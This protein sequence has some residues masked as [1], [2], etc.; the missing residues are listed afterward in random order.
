MAGPLLWNAVL[1][2]YVR[3]VSEIWPCPQISM[4]LIPVRVCSPQAPIVVTSDSLASVLLLVAVREAFTTHQVPQ[5]LLLVTCSLPCA[6]PLVPEREAGQ[7]PSVPRHANGDD[8]FP[9]D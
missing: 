6:L 8:S 7:L 4:F 9:L 5:A 2:R 1:G 3:V